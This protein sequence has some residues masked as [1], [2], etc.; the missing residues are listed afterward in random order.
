MFYC[1]NTSWHH[2]TIGISMLSWLKRIAIDVG[3]YEPLA[4]SNVFF[5]YYY[6]I[7]GYYPHRHREKGYYLKS[8]F[9]IGLYPF[10]IHFVV[11]VP[12]LLEFLENP[13]HKAQNF[14]LRRFCSHKKWKTVI[15]I[16]F[17]L[18]KIAPKARIFFG[19]KKDT[20]RQNLKNNTGLGDTWI[21][22]RLN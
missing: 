8:T 20:I 5:R 14:R 6:S 21:S 12:F 19:S 7:L 10:F 4:C 9:W 22:K 16:S 17:K 3:L 15:H 2:W 13:R 11:C 1:G 18:L